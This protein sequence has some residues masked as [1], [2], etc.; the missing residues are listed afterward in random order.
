VR[1]RVL[2]VVISSSGLLFLYGAMVGFSFAGL[3][4]CAFEY[5]TD[6]RLDFNVTPGRGFVEGL[7]GFLVR[8]VAGPYLVARFLGSLAGERH[9]PLLVGAGGVLVVV[10]SLSIGILIIS[11]FMA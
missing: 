4:A 6:E 11:S 10:W 1:L 7:S 8:I 5:V 3:A 2:C 9:H